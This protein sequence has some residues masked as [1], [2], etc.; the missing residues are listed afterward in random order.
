MIKDFR[1]LRP[2]DLQ[3]A[4][5]MLREHAGEAK[6]ICGGQSLLILMRQGLV[7]PEYLIDIKHLEE[8]SYIRLDEDGLRI[9]ATTTHRALEKS[10]ELAERY[11]IIP[12]MEETLASIQTRNWGTI[13][14]NLSHADPAGD[15]APVLI[16]LGAKVKLAKADGTREMALE[17][18]FLDYFETALEEDELLVEISV[19][20]VP[21]RTGVAFEKFTIIG[22]DM[23]IVSATARVTLDEGGRAAEARVVLGGAAPTPLRAK[24][25]EEVLVGEDLREELLEEAGRKASEECEPISDIH[26]SEGYRRELVRVLTKRMLRKAWQRAAQG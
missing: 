12:E 2:Q 3:E 5:G 4:L 19:P 9:G 10:K 15:P 16:A 14:G 17:D 25:A 1:Y 6:V 20:P 22:C 24:G 11:P 26:A 23:G 18:F 13:G 7:A 8:L 21:A